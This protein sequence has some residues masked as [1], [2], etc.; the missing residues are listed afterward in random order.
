MLNREHR[1]HRKL[2][3]KYRLGIYDIEYKINSQNVKPKLQNKHSNKF[4]KLIIY[5]NFI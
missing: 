2:N 1:E 5:K 4:L 3:K